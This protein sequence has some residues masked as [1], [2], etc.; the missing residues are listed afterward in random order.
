MLKKVMV[1]GANSFLAGHIIIELLNRGYFVRGMMRKTARVI[2]N[3][4]KLEIF[5]GNVTIEEEVIDAVEG[6]DILIH[7]AAMTDQSVAAYNTYEKV[8]VGG[9]RNVIKA[10][11]RHHVKK[12]IYVSTSN[13][14]GYGTKSDPGNEKLPLTGPFSRSAYS[15][16]KARAQ[17]LFLNAFKRS[18]IEVT[19][20]NPAFM[21][22]PKDQ[23][24]NS[25][26]IILRALGKRIVFIPPGGKNFIHVRDAANGICNAIDKGKNGEC[27]IL[28]NENLTYK[29][30]YLKIARV[31]G[32]K[33]ILVT[34]PKQLLL[35]IGFVGN[36]I[37]SAGINTPIS[38]TNMQILSLCNFYSA[39][40]AIKELHLPQTPVDKAIEEA[41][42]WYNQKDISLPS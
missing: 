18:D 39:A 13:V 11:D 17:S 5:H 37:R 27:Y 1:T 8:N 9:A 29:E 38:L 4:P 25:S 42:S 23:K 14:F 22:G 32:K 28:A 33:I 15:I 41:I 6:C 36:I 30:F 7:V 19:V 40:R 10:A 31:T 26:R 34:L 16:T 24:I 3:H 21:I 2:T 20:V 12:V 35:L